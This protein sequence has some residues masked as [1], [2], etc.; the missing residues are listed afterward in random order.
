[1]SEKKNEVV[2]WKGM[3]TPAHSLKKV[4]EENK[5]VA[6]YL[7]STVIEKNEKLEFGGKRHITFEEWQTLGNAYDVM[8]QTKILKFVDNKPDWGWIAE[9]EAIHIPTGNRVGYAQA[10]CFR[11]EKGRGGQTKN[12]V[13]S[14][15]QTRAGSKALRNALGWIVKLAGLEATP[16]EEM[17]NTD[18]QDKKRQNENND[19]ANM[20]EKAN[21][22]VEEELKKDGNVEDA[23]FT[24][25]DK[26]GQD[27]KKGT[28]KGTGKTGNKQEEKVSSGSNT[29]KTATAKKEV[30]SGVTEKVT[31]NKNAEKLKKEREKRGITKE[32]VKKELDEKHEKP[33]DTQEE[34]ATFKKPELDKMDGQ[35][36]VAHIRNG[37]HTAGEVATEQAIKRTLTKLFKNKKI[38]MD[39]RRESLDYLKKNS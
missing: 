17:M 15:A 20:A 29:K 27:M 6:E 16:A 25:K 37:I 19:L 35:E 26:K 23:E 31:D 32:D 11:S 24:V 10:T 7:A 2:E 28:T 18:I 39:Q 1:M 14:M 9:G 13:A 34:Q 4:V 8:V 3:A 5:V 38:N 12:Q 33:Y 36:L 22:K 30:K 21:K